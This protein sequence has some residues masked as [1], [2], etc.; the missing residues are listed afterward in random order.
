[1]VKKLNLCF[2]ILTKNTKDTCM[3]LGDSLFSRYVTLNDTM[4]EDM[5][6]Q[7]GA[8]NGCVIDEPNSF[9]RRHIC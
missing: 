9:N 2:I 8:G 3:C 4:V 5:A 6:T 7:V 1:M